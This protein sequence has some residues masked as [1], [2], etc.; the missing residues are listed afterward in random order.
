MPAASAL[1]DISAN[2]RGGYSLTVGALPALR[3]INIG[4]RPEIQTI[5]RCQ[6]I[7]GRTTQL[8]LL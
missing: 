6:R 5:G 2:G 1:T 4:H 3:G 7:T 8:A